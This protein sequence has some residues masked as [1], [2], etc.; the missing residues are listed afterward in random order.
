MWRWPRDSTCLC[1][2]TTVIGE[3]TPQRLDRHISGAAHDLFARALR[4]RSARFPPLEET[5][6]ETSSGSLRSLQEQ[7]FILKNPYPVSVNLRDRTT[8]KQAILRAS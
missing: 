8:R 1:C 3:D 6:A 5:A 7:A 4:F 2:R